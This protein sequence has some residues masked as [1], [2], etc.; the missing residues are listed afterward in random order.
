MLDTIL[1]TL[2]RILFIHKTALQRRCKDFPNFIDENIEVQSNKEKHPRV[3]HPV[4]KGKFKAK[5][6]AVRIQSPHS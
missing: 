6:Q 5:T 2:R 3:T 1:S 4:S